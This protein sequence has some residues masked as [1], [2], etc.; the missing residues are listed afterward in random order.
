MQILDIIALCH[1][2]SHIFLFCA[3]ADFFD[4]EIDFKTVLSLI[5]SLLTF[6][7]N[8]VEKPLVSFLILLFRQTRGS[9]AYPFTGM[10]NFGPFPAGFLFIFEKYYVC[11]KHL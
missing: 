1:I 10:S 7:E 5:F 11:K 2:L 4:L 3:L 8:G 9:R 6:G